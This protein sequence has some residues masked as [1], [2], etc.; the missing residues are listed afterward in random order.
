MNNFWNG[1]SLNGLPMPWPLGTVSFS[2]NFITAAA[3]RLPSGVRLTC[4]ESGKLALRI[5]AVDAGSDPAARGGGQAELRSVADHVA[6]MLAHDADQ[7]IGN[8]IT[9]L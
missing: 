4:D 7:R 2:M 6:R 9:Q 1:S 8:R 3:R 5:V